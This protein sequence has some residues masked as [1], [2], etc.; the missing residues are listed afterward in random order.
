MPTLETPPDEVEPERQQLEDEFA[1]VVGQFLYE[2]SNRAWGRTGASGQPPDEEFW[3]NERKMLAALLVAW[4]LRFVEAGI[5]HQVTAV[6][7][8]AGFGLSAQVNARA[9]AWAEKHALELAKNITQTS[10]ELAR[11]R[12]RNW[13]LS[14]SNDLNDL[15]RSLNEIIGP[16]WRAR[17]IAETEVTRAWDKAVDEVADEYDE[18][19]AY[20]WQAM[21]D[22]RTCPICGNLHGVIVAKGELFPGGFSGPPAHPRC[23]CRKLLV[24]R[25]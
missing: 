12:I 19:E 3:T 20:Q 8:P 24:V 9:A 10:K 4:L 7:T 16:E 15:A 6:L 21:I 18:I 14:D 22:E 2:Q 25:Q 13:F 11:Q 5:S 17:M 1:P 23:R